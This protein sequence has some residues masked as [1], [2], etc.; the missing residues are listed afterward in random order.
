MTKR[1]LRVA[2]LDFD[3][4]KNNLKRFLQSQTEFSDYDF[5]GSGLSVIIDLLSYNTHYNAVIAN[6]LIQELYL[7]TAVKRQSLGLISKRLGYIPRGYRAAKA[8]INVSIYMDASISNVPDTAYIYKN[9]PFTAYVND[10]T[11]LSFIANDTHVAT[12]NNGKYVFQNV[13]IIEGSSGIYKYTVSGSNQRFE[14]PSKNIDTLY[15]RVYVQTSSSSTEIV[16][17]KER[18]SVIDVNATDNVFF[19]KLNENLNYEIYFGD[20][21]IGN[22]PSIGNIVIIEYISTNGVIGNN[23]SD[24]TY[25]N[26]IDNSLSIITETVMSSVGGNDP[27][28]NDEIRYNA[29]NSVYVQDRAITGNDYE[30]IIS[31]II[32]LD[33]INVYGGETLLP[34]AYGKVFIC[35]KQS[36]SELPLSSAQKKSIIN[37]LKKYSVLTL[38]HEIVDPEYI[39]I[40]LSCKIRYNPDKTTLSVESL[41]SN[42]FNSI[43][44]YSNDTFNR[45][46]SEFQY[47]RFAAYVDNIDP[48]IVSNS[49]TIH[50]HKGKLIQLDVRANYDFKFYEQIKPSTPKEMSI[51]SSAF[52]VTK[53]PDHDMFVTD[54]EGVLYMYRIINGQQEIIDY[55]IGTV[56]YY[57]G[58]LNFNL[59]IASSTTNDLEMYVI[60]TEMN[61]KVEQNNILVVSPM[62]VVIQMEK[63]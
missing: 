30:H 27:E 33:S 38:T 50:L 5:E 9:T 49:T 4:I 26:S 15:T 35:L 2:E 37:A 17:W 28:T 41:K 46:D 61:I 23:I 45:F 18:T 62:D 10:T 58:T 39:N 43:I 7:D 34:P 24:F 14:I 54:N 3:T 29:Q 47:S 52:R 63:V 44:S 32:S 8:T 56:D 13:D 1:S 6:M 11:K 53:F 19:T 59:Q 55:N 31:N 48:C 42:I 16:E 51:R 60:P 20:G 12:L 36:G 21:I 40:G 25:A 22:K 57:T